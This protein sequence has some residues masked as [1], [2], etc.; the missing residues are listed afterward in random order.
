MRGVRPLEEE[1]KKRRRKK[2]KEKPRE[3]GNHPKSSR[4][5]SYDY[6]SWDKFDVVRIQLVLL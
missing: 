3:S 5:G 2:V 1:K 6:R 4:I